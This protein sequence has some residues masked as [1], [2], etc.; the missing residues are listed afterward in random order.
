MMKKKNVAMA[1]AAVTVAAPVAQMAVASTAF[2]AETNTVTAAEAIAE[3]AKLLEDTY[4]DPRETGELFNGDATVNGQ[5]YKN[6]VYSIHANGREIKT[7]GQLEKLLEK[8]EIE[9]T[10]V[11]ISVVNKGYRVENGN[12]VATELTKV[13]RYDAYVGEKDNKADY[14]NFVQSSLKAIKSNVNNEANNSNLVTNVVEYNAEG[15]DIS[16]P[17]IVDKNIHHVAVT[18]VNGKTIILDKYSNKLNFSRPVD[19]NGNFVD[20]TNV[21]N[22]TAAGLNIL[23]SVVGFENVAEYS[24]AVAYDIKPELVKEMVI[25]NNSTSINEDLSAFYN[26][27][28]SAEGKELL[29]VLAKKEAYNNGKKYNLTDISLS[30]IKHKDGVYTLVIAAK[31][32]KEGSA[33]P[34]GN[35]L[36]ITVKTTDQTKL[37]EFVADINTVMASLDKLEGI[38]N[39]A[40]RYTTL[41]GKNRFETAVE[42]SKAKNSNNVVLVGWD[43][44]TD[45][46]AAAPFAK[47]KDASILL[48]KKDEVPTVVMN[49]I[50][51][52]I[53]AGGDTVYIIGG[54]DVISE[55]VEAQ[56]LK[57][58]K[59]LN[60]NIKL[61][62]IAGKNRFE[63]SVEIAKNM[64]LQDE[65]AYVVGGF[66]EADAMSV[67]PL[68]AKTMSPIIVSPEAG[69]TDSAKNLL[70]I[71]TAI[72]DV[73]FIGGTNKISA[74]VMSDVR[75]AADNRKS[76]ADRAVKLKRVSGATRQDT[77]AEVL[78]LFPAYGKNDANTIYVAKDGM[79]NNSHLVDALTAARL[80]RPMVLSTNKLTDSQMQAIDKLDNNDGSTNLVQV[81]LGVASNIM[82]K[83]VSLISNDK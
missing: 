44:I 19:V 61:E 57:E 25:S 21:V 76:S 31:V 53:S 1:M 11:V 43:A 7:I 79:V 34:T 26:G 3:V 71:E 63:T 37:N 45:G 10:S 60:K 32:T 70:T 46:L 16:L 14:D 35:N 15:V 77:N 20:L 17:G 28:Y 24:K 18:L 38:I 54:T 62:R 66:G 74:Q 81:G 64:N 47:E 68:A 82:D 30:D 83:I 40:G 58:L 12:K 29:T 2:A 67:A 23:K 73:K 55:K 42:V 4:S 51:R 56:L 9:N 13:R 80:E 36:T 33:L 39:K 72:K 41:A 52:I 6:S 8:A 22:T 27:A 65:K 78:K 48:S 5:E 50:K 59:E 75:E 69:L 49:E